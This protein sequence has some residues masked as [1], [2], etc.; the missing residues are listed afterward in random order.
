MYQQLHHDSYHSVVSRAFS[1]QRRSHF[2]PAISAMLLRPRQG[3]TRTAWLVLQTFQSHI[4]NLK[5]NG[6]VQLFGRAC[7]QE[8]R[9]AELKALPAYC[10][11]ALGRLWVCGGKLP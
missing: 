5:T 7:Y 1:F 11:L 8:K 6:Y 4:D 3:S 10:S 9:S 2:S